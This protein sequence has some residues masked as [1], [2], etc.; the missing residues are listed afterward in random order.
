MTGDKP[1]NQMEP[2]D[3]RRTESVLGQAYSQHYERVMD[4]VRPMVMDDV[5]IRVLD[6]IEAFA[7]DHPGSPVALLWQKMV[8]AIGPGIPAG[9]AAYVERFTALYKEAGDIVF[10]ATGA[11]L[12]AL[13]ELSEYSA[14]HSLSVI[15]EDFLR[16]VDLEAHG[17]PDLNRLREDLTSR[18]HKRSGIDDVT[19]YSQ[20]FE[21]YGEIAAYLHLCRQG[22][23][24]ELVTTHKRKKTPDFKC[25]SR[26]GK[27]FFV[28]VKSLD[29]VGGTASNRAMMDDALE[30]AAELERQ[31]DEGEPVATEIRVIQPYREYGEEETYDPRSLIRAI[32]VLRQ[33]SQ[34]AFDGGPFE[35]GPTFALVVADRL[36]LPGRGRAL[37]P[38]Y[39]DGSGDAAIASGVLW[40]MAYGTDGT[41]IFR[42]P[43]PAGKGSLEGHL[44]GSGLF[45][46]ETRPFPGPGLIV[47]DRIQEGRACLGLAND[48]FSGGGDWSI[49]DTREVLDTVCHYWNDRENRQYFSFAHDAPMAAR[50]ADKA[51]G[52]RGGRRA[53]ETVA[54]GRPRLLGPAEAEQR[55]SAHTRAAAPEQLLTS[56]ELAARA[57]VKTRQSVH[58]WLRKGRIVGWQGARRGYLFPPEQLDDR[59]RPLVGLDRVVGLFDDGYAA[60]VWLTT[61]LTSLDGAMPLTLLAR[62]EI[63]RVARAAEGDR[64]GDFA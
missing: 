42:L 17:N 27:T 8:E 2:R 26:S 44:N 31:H 24:T 5:S 1:L 14:S 23:P 48:A 41:P 59:G 18:L 10:P 39:H 53:A 57:G 51:D 30:S 36:E 37:A 22:V 7:N 47:L 54:G 16:A 63:D 50:S 43:D 15:E 62:G 20:A 34:R 60:W 52:L 49:D 21:T 64:Q 45:S 61:E 56:D 35:R 11:F 32:K 12:A 13:H 38:Y 4:R 25:A 33:K 6:G 55:M 28:E 58:D 3:P 19:A 29:V 46:D 9:E 40:H